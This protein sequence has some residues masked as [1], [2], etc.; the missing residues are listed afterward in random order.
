[1]ACASWLGRL[2]RATGAAEPATSMVQSGAKDVYV[3]RFDWDEEPTFLGTD[4]SRMLGAAHGLEGPLV[5]GHFDL[6]RE[7]SRLFTA[8]NEPGRRELSDAMMSYWAQF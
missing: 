4:L 8:G 2:W 6:G 1:A 7:A 5:F 3:Y